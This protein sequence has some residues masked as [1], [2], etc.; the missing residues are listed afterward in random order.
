MTV[1]Q[2]STSGTNNG[3]TTFKGCTNVPIIAKS[4]ALDFSDE[5]INITKK[6]KITT[7]WPKNLGASDFYLITNSILKLFS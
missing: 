6:K 2:P 4:Q 5:A 1:N 7:V 3:T